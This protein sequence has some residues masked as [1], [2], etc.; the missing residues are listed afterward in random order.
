M[1]QEELIS[2]NDF[3]THHRVE[4]SFLQS[5]QDYGLVALTTIQERLFLHPDQ[6]NTVEKFMHLHYDLEVNF[7]GLDIIGH[8]L[9]RMEALQQE[10]TLL[11][12]RLRF[13]ESEV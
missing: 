3:C 1:V 9:E 2:A 6:L 8:M 7:E 11:K 13:R 5:L 10:M 12:N 4:V